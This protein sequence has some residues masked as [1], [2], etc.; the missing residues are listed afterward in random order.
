MPSLAPHFAAIQGNGVF[1]AFVRHLA[2]HIVEQFVFYENHRVGVAHSSFEHAFSVVWRGGHNDFEARD[3]RIESFEHLRVLRATLRA[4]AARSANDQRHFRL[5]TKHIAEF[6]GAINNQIAGEQ[7]EVDGHEFENWAQ[8]VER[9]TDSGSR[10][11]FFSQGRIADALFAKF[12][13]KS[14]T[15]SVGAA[16]SRDVFAQDKDALI[17]LHFFANGL[18][19]GITIG[20]CTHV[21]S[22]L[23]VLLIYGRSG[24]RGL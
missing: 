18:A 17:A 13:K 7:A 6:G 23:R 12:F 11:D 8:A 16:V 3:V 9:G 14:F 22:S 1:N 5:A 10:N 19:Q 2:S 15:H 4:T 20:D 24:T 21:V